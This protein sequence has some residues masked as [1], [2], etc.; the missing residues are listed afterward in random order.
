MKTIKSITCMS[1]LLFIFTLFSPKNLAFAEEMDKVWDPEKGTISGYIW[2]DENE[3]GWIDPEEQTIAPEIGEIKLYLI[4]ENEEIVEEKIV[5]RLQN[6]QA[7]YY[8]EVEEGKYKIR[9]EFNEKGKYQLTRDG[10]DSFFNSTT[11]E[12]RYYEIM[13]S[14]NI[15]S[16]QLGYKKLLKSI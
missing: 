16:I 14:Y 2:F 3:D 11:N 9:A 12:T 13:K 5:S 15:D 10:R 8:F 1:V 7:H 4:N 6:G